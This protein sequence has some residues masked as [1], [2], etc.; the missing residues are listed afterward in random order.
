MNKVARWKTLLE[1]GTLLR[2][3]WQK[4]GSSQSTALRNRVT[5]KELG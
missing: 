1:P 2:D 3:K 5:S 4:K